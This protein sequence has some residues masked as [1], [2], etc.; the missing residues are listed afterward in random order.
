[1]KRETPE[2]SKQARKAMIDRGMNVTQ[3]SDAIGMA[4][5]Y[6]SA[7]LNGRVISPNAQIVICK[8]LKIKHV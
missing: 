4:R 1:M 6:V 5:S 8:Y 7:I 3:L 2:W